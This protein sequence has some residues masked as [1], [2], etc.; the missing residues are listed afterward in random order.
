MNIFFLDILLP[1]CAL[2]HGDKHVVKMPLEAVQLLYTAKWMLEP[3]GAWQASAPWNKAKTSRGYKK[4]HYNH[5]LAVWVRESL[6]NYMYC[7]EHALAL[8]QEYSKRFQNKTLL[9]E[10]HA[11]WL[12][13]NPPANLPD[14]GLTPIPLCV[15]DETPVREADMEVVVQRY[16]HY[17]AT[18]KKDIAKYRHSPAP[19]WLET[20]SI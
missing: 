19:A 3:S 9:A 12:K 13:E 7:V 10:E 18:T 4:T 15:G 17:Y 1:L 8:C 11:R 20:S 16:R 6:A 2:Y 14:L 5:P